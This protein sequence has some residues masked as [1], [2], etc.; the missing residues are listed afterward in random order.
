MCLETGTVDFGGGGGGGGA[1]FVPAVFVKEEVPGFVP[2]AFVKEVVPEGAG[3]GLVGLAEEPVV[4]LEVVDVVFLA[5]VLDATVLV[6][7]PRDTLL[8]PVKA[9][10]ATVSAVGRFSGDRNLHPA[11]ARAPMLESFPST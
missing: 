2:D 5:A 3:A 10:D 1:G 9:S 11:K 6:G 7:M 8:H 4:V